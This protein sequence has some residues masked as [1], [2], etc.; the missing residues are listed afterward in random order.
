MMK[1]T[2]LGTTL[3]LL[4]K[5]LGI[6]V[7]YPM[8]ESTII[9]NE[10]TIRRMRR[11]AESLSERDRR[12]YV[13]VEAYKSGS[14]GVVVVAGIFG[15]S[16]ETI[17]KG[18]DDLDSPERLPPSGR[19]RHKGAGRKGVCSEQPGLEA[20]FDALIETHLGGD[21]MNEDVVWTDLQPSGIVAKLND[22]GFSISE[23]TVRALLKKRDPQTHAREIAGNRRSGSGASQR[24]V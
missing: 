11:L 16:T 4:K 22:Q 6:V 8:I 1:K 24:P 2:S 21:P 20:V 23:N 7:R 9:Y 13:A 12:A 17:K 10:V 15:M 14:P 19:Q 18:R 3:K 5:S